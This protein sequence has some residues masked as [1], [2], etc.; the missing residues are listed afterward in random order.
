MGILFCDRDWLTLGEISR[1]LVCG[2]YFGESR[3]YADGSE[4][5]TLLVCLEMAGLTVQFMFDAHNDV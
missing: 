5:K 1:P 3:S 2:F 4:S